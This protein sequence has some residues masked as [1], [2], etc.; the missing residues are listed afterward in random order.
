MQQQLEQVKT[1]QLTFGQKVAEKP[2]LVDLEKAHLRYDL[3]K[4]E[5]DEYLEAVEQDDLVGVAD[6]LTD[7]LYI[8]CGTILEHGMQHIIEDCFTEVQNSNLSK[9]DDEGKPIINGENG[10]FDES[11]PLG[12]ILKSTNFREPNLKQFLV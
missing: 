10:V 7:Q 9:L 11:R 6:S 4:E 5:L 2:Q 8:L 12:K 1:F 3:G